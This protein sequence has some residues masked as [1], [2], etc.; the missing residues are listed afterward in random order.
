MLRGFEAAIFL[1]FGTA[2]GILSTNLSFLS[3]ISSD[4][5][6]DPIFIA[7]GIALIFAVRLF[8]K[9]SAKVV[10]NIWSGAYAAYIAVPATKVFVDRSL[11]QEQYHMFYVSLILGFIISWYLFRKAE[12]PARKKRIMD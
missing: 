6:Q 7:V 10:A 2:V 12:M 11:S 1:F 4:Y 5:V 9:L 8:P 3:N